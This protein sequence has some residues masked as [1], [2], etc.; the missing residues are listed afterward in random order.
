MGLPPFYDTGVNEVC[1]KILSQS[2]QLPE[3]LSPAAKDILAKLLTREPDQRLGAKGVS[4]IKAH[5]FF[6]DIDWEMLAQREYM[7]PIKPKHPIM[8]FQEERSRSIVDF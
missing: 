2:L 7:P 8:L 5:P 3:S 4:E 6:N 1:R